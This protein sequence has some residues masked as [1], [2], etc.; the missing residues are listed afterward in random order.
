MRPQTEGHSGKVVDD[1]DGVAVFGQID[2]TKKI[3]A[4]LACLDADVRELLGDIHRKLLLFIFPAVGAKNPAELP[5]LAAKRTVQE[6]LSAVSFL[7]E[8]AKQGQGIASGTAIGRQREGRGKHGARYKL[9]ARL[10]EGARQKFFERFARF[11]SWR[12]F[13]QSCHPEFFESCAPGG[14]SLALDES[15]F[16]G[17]WARCTRFD[18]CEERLERLQ[19]DGQIQLRAD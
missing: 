8:D 7:P 11:V 3:F 6:A 2:R 19:E 14:L 10:K 13:L 18:E 4:G 17:E 1:G 16:S 9:G 5:F 12:R 15:R